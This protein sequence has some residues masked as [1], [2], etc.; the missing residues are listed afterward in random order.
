[1]IARTPHRGLVG[2]ADPRGGGVVSNT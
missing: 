2:V 1:L